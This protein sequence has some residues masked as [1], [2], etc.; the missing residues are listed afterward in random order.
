MMRGAARFCSTLLVPFALCLLCALA[1]AAQESDPAAALLEEAARHSAKTATL[2]ADFRQ[3]KK[4]GVLTQPLTSQGYLCATR[5][6]SSPAG[7]RLLWAY[8]SPAPSGFLYENGQGALWEKHPAEKR[9]SNA[10][11]ARV[12]TAIVEHILAWIRIDAKVLQESYRIERPD[13]DKPILLLYPR[14]QSFFIRLEAEFAPK[15][16][17]VRQLTFFEANGDT[18]RILFTD[19]QINQPLPERCSR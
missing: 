18:V 5:G 19:I 8:V 1:H 12:V 11:E 14:R 3:E 2:N 15:L 17:S 9:P 7:Q 13:K 6:Q 16:D 4:L 10:Q